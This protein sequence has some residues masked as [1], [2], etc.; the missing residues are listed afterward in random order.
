MHVHLS[1]GA[2]AFLEYSQ[3]ELFIFKTKVAAVGW[4]PKVS[5]LASD[6]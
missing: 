4:L 3:R 1:L 2:Q 6:N 5:K